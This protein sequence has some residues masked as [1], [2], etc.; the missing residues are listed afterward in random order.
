MTQGHRLARRLFLGRVARLAVAALPLARPALAA[1][2]D[3]RRLEFAHTHTGESLSVVYAVG[4]QFVPEALAALNHFLR[5]HYSGE[6]GRID[7]Q[8][9]EL[10]YRTRRELG[11]TQ[12]FQV[13]SGY[14]CATTN[15]ALRDTRG[16]G[17]ARRSLHMEGKAIDIR[18]AD[19]SLGD[20][21]TAA[22][23]QRTGGVGFY[24]REDFVHLDTGR[25]RYW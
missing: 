12:P 6:V 5:D 16:G 24:P 18:L 23:A 8:L 11:S 17:V 9:F 10:L 22:I 14:R 21:R 25:V 13:I 20:L 15:S 4:E 1:L 2:P 3:A 19:A 7:P